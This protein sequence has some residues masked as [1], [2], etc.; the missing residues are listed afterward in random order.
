MKGHGGVKL[1]LASGDSLSV[2]RPFQ[3]QEWPGRLLQQ[4]DSLWVEEGAQGDRQ[5]VDVDPG[6]DAAVGVHPVDAGE[7]SVDL[8]GHRLRHGRHDLVDLSPV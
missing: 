8:L 1:V 4:S 7:E 5:A 6:L 2:A 3:V